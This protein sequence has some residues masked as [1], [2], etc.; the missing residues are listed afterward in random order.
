M[1]LSRTAPG[2]GARRR[3]PDTSIAAAER[4][5]NQRQ[6]DRDL[7]LVL[8]RDHPEGLTDFELADLMG[9]QQTSAG[10]RR[11][12]LRDM[13]FIRATDERRP[14]PSGSPAIVWRYV[15]PEERE[16]KRVPFGDP[17]EQRLF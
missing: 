11:G 4:E 14:A 2:P 6:R 1:S 8:H 9:R 10:K 13:G 7:A 3:D 5:P 16:P 12:E 17:V 15:P